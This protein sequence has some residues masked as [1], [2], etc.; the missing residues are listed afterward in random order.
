MPTTSDRRSTADTVLRALADERR[1]AVLGVL[2][3]R[4]DP[5][6]VERVASALGDRVDGDVETTVEQL[7]H[8]HLPKL[9]AAGLVRYDPVAGRVS[10]RESLTDAGGLNALL[11]EADRLAPRG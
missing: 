9:E 2:E 3:E 7:H 5:V 8:T 4:E 1:R 10:A 6:D 11:T